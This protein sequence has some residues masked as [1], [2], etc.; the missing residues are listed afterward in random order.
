MHKKETWEIVY[1]EFKNRSDLSGYSQWNNDVAKGQRP[2]L[3]DISESNRALVE[4]SRTW[5]AVRAEDVEG[6]DSQTPS[7]ESQSNKIAPVKETSSKD[8]VFSLSNQGEDIASIGNYS[9]PLNETALAPTQEEVASDSVVA[10]NTT[11]EQTDDIAPLP[12]DADAPPV[13]ETEYYNTPDTTAIWRTSYPHFFSKSAKLITSPFL[14]SNSKY[15]G[16]F[17]NRANSNII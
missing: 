12:T 8:G 5:R 14:T 9:T 7:A 16:I 4:Y 6:N 10:E 15:L 17:F 13:M 1:E 11:V 2:T 3:T